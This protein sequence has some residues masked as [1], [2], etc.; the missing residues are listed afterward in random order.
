MKNAI[1]FFLLLSFCG[2]I[3]AQDTIVT[4]NKEK[5]PG[6]VVFVGE[7]VQYKKAGNPDG[8][9]YSTKAENVERILYANGMVDS[10]LYVTP[11]PEPKS[12]PQVAQTKLIPEKKELILAEGHGYRYRN[13][14]I[15]EKGVLKVA[16]NSDPDQALKQEIWLVKDL[17]RKQIAAGIAGAGLLVGAVITEYIG[18]FTMASSDISSAAPVF[19]FGGVIALGGIAT[20]VASLVFKAKRTQHVRAVV[21]LYNEQP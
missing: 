13:R 7:V 17:K 20:E 1:A 3:S 5:I 10:I 12:K 6:K 11:R 8:P 19:E 15:S 21:D 18:L 16:G 14:R 9:L 4:K 2:K